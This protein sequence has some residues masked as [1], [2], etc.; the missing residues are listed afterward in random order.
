MTAVAVVANPALT[1][2][3]ASAAVAPRYYG[4]NPEPGEAQTPAATPAVNTASPYRIQFQYTLLDTLPHNR[5]SFTQ[6][7]IV[8]GDELIESSGLYGKSFLHRYPITNGGPAADQS[9][10]QYKLLPKHLFAEGI[11]LVDNKLYLLTWQ[12]RQALVL[13][14]HT[15][16]TE[17]VFRYRGEGWGLSAFPQTTAG[18]EQIQLVMSNGSDQLSFRDPE[19]FSVLRTLRVTDQGQPLHNLNDLAVAQGLIW[20]NVWYSTEIVAIDPDSGEVVGKID[21]RAQADEQPDTHPT[22]HPDNVLNGIAWDEQRQGFWVTGKRWAKR[23]FIRVTAVD[24]EGTS[25]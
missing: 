13:N 11:A 21:L 2:P 6:G 7:L 20:A 12:N 24:G 25:R 14:P 15:L 8:D 10:V 3:H 22:T 17:N 1:Q 4:E 5:H 9:K 18:R 19:T 23:Y 16:A